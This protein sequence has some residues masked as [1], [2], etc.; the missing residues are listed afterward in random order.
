MWIKRVKTLFFIWSDIFREQKSSKNWIVI[1]YFFTP[2]EKSI[3][4]WLWVDLYDAM[5]LL[6]KTGIF[7]G[8][9]QVK[10]QNLFYSTRDKK[11]VEK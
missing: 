8:V 9:P 5:S 3:Y 4:Y 2:S 7:T 11:V 6:K 10:T 1:R